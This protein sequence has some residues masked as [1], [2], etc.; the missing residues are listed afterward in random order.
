MN[1]NLIS[2][3]TILVLSY[4][5][6]LKKMKERDF[7]RLGLCLIQSRIRIRFS[8]DPDPDQNYTDPHSALQM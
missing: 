4:I 5:F 3:K 1:N 7:L 6:Y 2:I 8:P